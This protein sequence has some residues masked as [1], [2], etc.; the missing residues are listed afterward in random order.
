MRTTGYYISSAYN[1]EYSTE[2]ESGRIQ[3]ANR[4]KVN[5]TVSYVEF[6]KPWLESLAADFGRQYHTE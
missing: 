3:K 5:F 2:T 4:V 1:T 6:L